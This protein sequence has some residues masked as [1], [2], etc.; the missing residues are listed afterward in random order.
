MNT[1]RGTQVEPGTYAPAAWGGVDEQ[2]GEPRLNTMA[3]RFSADGDSWWN[4]AEWLPAVSENG[5]WR[6][7]GTGWQPQVSADLDAPRLVDELERLAAGRYIRRGEL[8]VQRLT[9]WTPPASLG[10]RA[11]E[12][13]QLMDRRDAAERRLQDLDARPRQGIAAWVSRLVA[14]LNGATDER[15]RLWLDRDDLSETL[16]PMLLEIGRTAPAPTFRESEEAMEMASRISREASRVS[17]ANAAL[18]AA[19]AEWQ[20]RVQ[21]RHQHVQETIAQ[22][23]QTIAQAEQAVEDA[24]ATR[25]QA[26]VDGW[27][28]LAQVRM[29]GSGEE[30]SRF[31]PLQLCETC[32]VTPSGTGPTAGARAMIGTAQELASDAAN[33]NGL[34]LVGAPGSAE[35]HEA[36]ARDDP[37]PFL[38]VTTDWVSAVVPC[39]GAEDDARRFAERLAEASAAAEEWRRTRDEEVIASY[40]AIDAARSDVS[41]IEAALTHKEQMEADEELLQAIADAREELEREQQRDDNVDRAKEALNSII[42]ELWT[43]PPPLEVE[44]VEF[45]RDREDGSTDQP[46]AW[47]STAWETVEWEAPAAESE[48]GREREDEPVA[49]A[50]AANWAPHSGPE[51][52][53]P[54][55]RAAEPEVEVETSAEAPEPDGVPEDRAVEWEEPETAAEPDGVPEQRAAGWEEPQ[56]AAEPEPGAEAEEPEAPEPEQETEPAQSRPRRRNAGG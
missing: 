48:A 33:V 28:R 15:Q 21:S 37:T 20:L 54:E 4:G 36:E 56:A 3:T 52:W 31:G 11:R 30:L 45:S 7:D 6:W 14:R 22:R 35:L 34:F 24:R 40:E 10:G 53:E 1:G 18:A 43:P 47:E 29:P 5:F 12:A 26:I 16:R 49:K 23:D 55:G 19:Q 32:V 17:A 8:L 25:E 51:A 50:E 27:D 41:S 42:E 46:S 38:L 13:R 9:D 44:A 2:G 39:Y